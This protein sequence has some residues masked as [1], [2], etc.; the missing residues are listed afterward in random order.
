MPKKR[1]LTFKTKVIEERK[2][3]L[4]KFLQEIVLYKIFQNDTDLMKFLEVTDWAIEFNFDGEN[5][6]THLTDR[7]KRA[8]TVRDGSIEDY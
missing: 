2:L 3:L 6:E 5:K 4:E 7:C 8:R 1:W